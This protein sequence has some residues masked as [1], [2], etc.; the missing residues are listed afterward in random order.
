MAGPDCPATFPRKA[1]GGRRL[2]VIGVVGGR[3]FPFAQLNK[4]T[5]LAQ[6]GSFP[7]RETIKNYL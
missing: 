1:Y 3:L 6:K 7:T 2:G 5:K 4:V